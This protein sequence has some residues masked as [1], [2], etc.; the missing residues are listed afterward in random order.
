MG[1]KKPSARRRRYTCE[2][3][4]VHRLGLTG[5]I[6]AGKSTVAGLLRARGFTVLD[7]DAV[8]REV[9][10]WPG[11]R[12]DVAEQ[13][14]PQF[15]G[16]DGLDRP[17]LAALVFA[18]PAKLELLNGIV[19]PRVRARMAELERAARGR[20]VVQ[21]VPLL[22]ENNLDAKM[23]ATLLVDAPL[24]TRLK[25][26]VARGGLTREQAL[27]RDAA[28]LP[29]EE[30]RRRASYTLDNSGGRT[31]LEGQLDTA[32]AALGVTP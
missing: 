16:V 25:R 31:A 13:L 30:K 8:A 7:A 1:E 5:S 24:E 3:S 32:L 11:V 14:G 17:A 19:H 21:D 10:A 27:A 28:Q 9:S 23:N 26:V 2:V 6:G 12:R 15:L 22:F 4:D 18:N 20:W 29:A